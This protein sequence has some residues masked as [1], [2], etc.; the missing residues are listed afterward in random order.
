M[1]I[2]QWIFAKTIT[3]SILFGE[4]NYFGCNNDKS[5][6][7][8]SPGQEPLPEHNFRDSHIPYNF[9]EVGIKNKDKSCSYER[10]S[11]L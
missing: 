7:P 9:P 6:F 11:R 5:I 4:F 8:R 3:K 1:E 2:L 10:K